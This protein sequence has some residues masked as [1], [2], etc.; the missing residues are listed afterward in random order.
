MAAP[1]RTPL[2]PALPFR[3]RMEREARDLR[4]AAEAAWLPAVRAQL[5]RRVE[6]FE[7]ASLAD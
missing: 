3:E 5:M 7:N 6:E 1:S 4:T 2:D